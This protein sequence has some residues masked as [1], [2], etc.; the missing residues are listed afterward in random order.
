VS[1]GLVLAAGIV[2]VVVAAA[3]WAWRTEEDLP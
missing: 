1:A 2:S 3:T